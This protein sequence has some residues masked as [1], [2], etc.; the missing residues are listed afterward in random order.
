MH[1]KKIIVSASNVHRRHQ[2]VL[3]AYQKSVNNKIQF[4]VDHQ[5]KLR[6]KRKMSTALR[7]GNVVSRVFFEKGSTTGA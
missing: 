4:L 1:I 3:K 2:M 6:E 5:K 7:V